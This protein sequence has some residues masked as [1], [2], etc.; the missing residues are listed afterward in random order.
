VAVMGVCAAR[1]AA[2]PPPAPNAN[3]RA[4]H[5]SSLA[6]RTGALAL[7][8]SL[9]PAP[10]VP[11]IAQ[12][13]QAA[14]ALPAGTVRDALLSNLMVANDD[15]DKLRTSIA[16]WYDNSMERLSG[17]YKRQLKLITMLI[18]LAVPVGFND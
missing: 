2:S 11:G 4:T 6:G 13:K 8:G 1:P 7:L 3:Q 18:G 14:L 5:L 9:D 15:V 12:I 16:T 10:P 17:A